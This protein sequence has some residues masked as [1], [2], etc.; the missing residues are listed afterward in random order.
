MECLLAGI[1]GII[2]LL[3][4]ILIT[5]DNDD[6]HR[7]RLI[8]VLQRLD[9]AGLTVQK[10]KCD[11]FKDEISYLGHIVDKNG[12]RTSPEKIN[13][14]Q[15]TKPE[16]VSQLQSFLGLTNYYRNFIPDASSVLSPLYNL[17][18]KNAKSEWTIA[19]DNAFIKVKNI[20]SSD[21]TL[22]HFNPNARIILTID[23]SPTGLGA[24]LSQIDKDMIERPIS[25]AS[26]TLTPAEKNYAQI[27]KEATAII[28]GVRQFHQYLCG[29]SQP[30][31]K[32][33][34]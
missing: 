14:L 5:A 21:R 27:Q 20:L 12:I 22:A 33:R 24:V 15:V 3:D 25:Y 10:S 19:H 4:D 9:D 31:V 8:T 30:F 16:S 18:N 17:L 34:P 32:D 2:F 13:I 11:F 6:Q 7:Q 1:D 29:S 28:F 23:A 26:R